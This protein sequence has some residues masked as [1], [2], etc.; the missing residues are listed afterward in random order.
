[1]SEIIAWLEQLGLSQYAEI[2]ETS[3]IDLDV[4]TDL[5]EDDLRELSVSFGHRKR[6]LRAIATLRSDSAGA[7]ESAVTAPATL[8]PALPPSGERRLIT[9]LFCDMVGSTAMTAAGDPEDMF[10]LI[11]AYHAACSEVIERFG[12]YV[13][14][15]VGDG[16]LAY[17]GYPRAMEGEAERA[18]R[19]ALALREAVAGLNRR[20]GPRLAIRIGIDTG[21][22]VI[23]DLIARG[24]AEEDAAIGDTPNLAARLQGTA[25]PGQI[26]ISQNTRRLIGSLFELTDGGVHELKGFTR[27]VRRFTV[28][29]EAEAVSRFAARRGGSDTPLVGRERYLER[30]LEQWER[31]A[32]GQGRVVLIS[33]EPG[34]G[35]SHLVQSFRQAV[36]DLAPALFLYECSPFYAN[37]AF[38]VLANQ[39][40]WAA[41][42][43]RSDTPEERLAKLETLVVPGVDPREAVPLMGFL[44]GVPTEHRYPR[45]DLTPEARKAAIFALARRQLD[46][47]AGAGPV[48][49]I[50]E[51]AHWID[52]SSGELLAERI[53]RVGNHRHLIVVTYRSE[54]AL[55]WLE[56]IKAVRL[57]LDPL[58]KADA[59]SLMARVAGEPLP[60]SL[61]DRIWEKSDGVPLFVEEITKAV[62]ESGALDADAATA[63]LPAFAIPATLQESLTARLDRLSTVKEVVQHAAVLGRTFS[64]DVLREMAALEDRQLKR[65]LGEL[66]N[67]ELLEMRGEPPNETYVFRHALLQET[68]Y[69]SLL[70]PRRQMLHRR[71]ARALNRLRPETVARTPELLAYHWQEANDPAAAYPYAMQAGERALA[72]YANTEARVRF[73]EAVQAASQLDYGVRMEAQA[74]LRQA[75]VAGTRETVQA[76]LE[77]LPAIRSAAEELGDAPLL[78]AIDYWIGRL[79]YVLGDFEAAIV[80]ATRSF[81][82]A[83][84]TEGGA[85]VAA[86]AGNLLARIHAIQGTPRLA[87]RFAKRNAAQMAALG[88]TQEQAAITSVLAF[89]YGVSGQFEEAIAAADQAVHLAADLEHWPTKAACSFYRGVVLGWWGRIVEAE[90]DFQNALE[91]SYAC[92]DLFRVYV[93]LGWRGQALLQCNELAAAETDLNQCLSLAQDIGTDFHRGAFLAYRA[94]LDLRYG[95]DTVDLAEEAVALSEGQPW[96]QSIALRVLGEALT[97]KAP[98]KANDALQK[99]IMLQRS[100]EAWYDLAWTKLALGRLQ[101]L[102]GDGGGAAAALNEARQAFAAMQVRAGLAAVCEVE[103]G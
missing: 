68:V 12:G 38:Q 37:S 72:R 11:R 50:V 5:N 56:D 84:T 95:R 15:M 74:L 41:G 21:L 70:R 4:L 76:D 103:R 101:M 17:F 100:R 80:E 45:L 39:I 34:I 82:R 64:P 16:V 28:E 96:A 42:L 40:G 46:V 49:T 26:V 7:A 71:A 25:E 73:A 52:P 61:Q 53:A 91:M 99:A 32:T 3:D 89:G 66:M 29:A 83:E 60:G 62:L 102:S 30:L 22:V 18:V 63:R 33:G 92:N 19:A 43:K 94:A 2:F 1:V 20:G 23:G 48:L 14:R 86:D 9:V 93:T 54:Q 79:H 44:C 88:N 78:A 57:T 13:A 55:A 67:A 69:T 31:A 8:Q 58:E 85:R 75:S 47:L 77:D 65:A 36:A 35:K 59:V 27:P 87:V 6:L 90:P 51:D 24:N 98:V 10:E 81:E 97:L